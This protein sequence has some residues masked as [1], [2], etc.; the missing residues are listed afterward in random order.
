MSLKF[1]VVSVSNSEISIENKGNKHF[2]QFPR[3]LGENIEKI[4]VTYNPDSLEIIYAFDENLDFQIE[5]PIVETI[6]S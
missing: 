5:L 2:Y 1:N 6:P 4:N 3:E